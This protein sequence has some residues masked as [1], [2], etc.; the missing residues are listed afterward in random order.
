MFS[1]FNLLSSRAHKTVTWGIQF[2]SVNDQRYFTINQQGQVYISVP[3]YWDDSNK[4]P[5]TFTV[6]ATNNDGSG[7]SG[8]ISCTVNVNRNLFPPHFSQPVYTVNISSLNSVPVVVNAGVSASDQ[9]TFARYQVLMYEI[10]ND[11]VYSQLFSI[12]NTTGLL[13]LIQ[14]IDE[15][16]ECTY[17]VSNSSLS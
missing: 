2:N 7:K 10:I 12:E 13:R 5:Y 14:P 1:P 3:L 9:D 16:T 4:T 15:R 11:G 17:K 8:S 6:T